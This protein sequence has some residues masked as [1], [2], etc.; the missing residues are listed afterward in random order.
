MNGMAIKGVES[1]LDLGF[2]PDHKTGIVL[3]ATRFADHFFSGP[4]DECGNMV[5]AIV[6]SPE[7]GKEDRGLRLLTLSPMEEFTSAEEKMA[8]GALFAMMMGETDAIAGFQAFEHRLSVATKDGEVTTNRQDAFCQILFTHE[9]GPI[10]LRATAFK[11]ND[12]GVAVPLGAV[13]VEEDMDAAKGRLLGSA[14]RDDEDD[15]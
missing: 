6:K 11:R 10:Q 7:P 2:W 9:D 4:T 15:E 1:H 12:E 5:A 8:W 3:L 13:M 14:S